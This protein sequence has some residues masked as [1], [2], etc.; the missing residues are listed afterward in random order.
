MIAALQSIKPS[1]RTCGETRGRI[2]Y[3][4]ENYA[5]PLLFAPICQKFHM[6][7]HNR[8]RAPGYAASWPKIVK[9]H[10]DGAKW[11]EQLL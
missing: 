7:L 1:Q 9:A 5:G 11:F 6:A 8:F 2:D 10:A 3:H 4:A